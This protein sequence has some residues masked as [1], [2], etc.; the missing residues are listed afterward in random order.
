MITS[1]CRACPI[2]GPERRKK[3]KIK[4]SEQNKQDQNSPWEGGSSLRVLEIS[5]P[6]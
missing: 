6:G 4:L 3:R 1:P 5:T 2:I